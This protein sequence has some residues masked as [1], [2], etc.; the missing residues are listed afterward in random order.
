MKNEQ[1]YADS[2]ALECAKALQEMLRLADVS[3]YVSDDGSIKVK[4]RDMDIFNEYLEGLIDEVA[5]LGE[6]SILLNKRKRASREGA[7][8]KLFVDPDYFSGDLLEFDDYFGTN[9]SAE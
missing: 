2:I 6:G 1:Y 5:D 3:V 8:V 9:I 7:E 4:D